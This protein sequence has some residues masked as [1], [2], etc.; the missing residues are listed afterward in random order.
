MIEIQGEKSIALKCNVGTLEDC[1]DK[2][3]G[4]IEKTAKKFGGDR[5]EIEEE[6]ARLYK[7]DKKAM[8]EDRIGIIF[9]SGRLSK[10][11]GLSLQEHPWMPSAVL[12]ARKYNIPIIPTHISARNS[13]LF[14]LLDIIHPTLRDIT[15]FN[16]TLNKKD[17]HFEIRF[18][19]PVHPYMLNEQPEIATSDLKL[20]VL[21]L[22]ARHFL[23]SRRLRVHRAFNK[24]YYQS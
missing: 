13:L 9:P 3:K 10:R 19:E 14:Y 22:N 23:N 1:D 18:G 11:N 24:I 4:Y 15:L 20:R 12:L 7:I 21:N 2:M 17:F 16:E 5:D 8:K 6:L